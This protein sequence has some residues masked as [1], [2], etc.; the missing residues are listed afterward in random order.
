MRIKMLADRIAVLLVICNARDEDNWNPWG[1]ERTYDGDDSM[2]Y[3]IRKMRDYKTAKN[4][5]RMWI[6]K[7]DRATRK[8]MEL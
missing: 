5:V 6:E 4:I 8:E 7:A 1:L 2:G 3:H